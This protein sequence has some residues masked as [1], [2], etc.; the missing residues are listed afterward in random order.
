MQVG[1]ELGA[2]EVVRARRAPLASRGLQG[3]GGQTELQSDLLSK[4]LLF[5]RQEGKG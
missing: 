3:S 4:D 2:K 5:W 1:R